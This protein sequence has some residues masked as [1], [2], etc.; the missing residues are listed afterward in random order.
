MLAKRE[1]RLRLS[2]EVRWDTAAP[3]QLL[4]IKDVLLRA[5]LREDTMS[6]GR[7]RIVSLLTVTIATAGVAAVS[8][9]PSAWAAVQPGRNGAPAPRAS[10]VGKGVLSAVSATSASNAWAVG[11]AGSRRWEHTVILRWNGT[12]WS[13]VASPDPGSFGSSLSAVSATSRTSAW[14]VGIYRGSSAFASTALILHWNGTDWSKAG[15][16]VPDVHSELTAVSGVSA[17]SAWAVGWYT[18]IGANRSLILHWNGTRWSKVPSPDPCPYGNYLSAVSATSPTSAWAVGYCYL[19]SGSRTMILHWNGTR[20]SRVPSP[21]P[22]AGSRLTGVAALSGTA[23]WAVGSDDSGSLILRWNGTRWTRVASPDPGPGGNYL[24]AV[25][26][27]SRTSAWAVGRYGATPDTFRTLTLHW[28][29]TRWTKVA[30]P[31]HETNSHDF[32]GLNGVSATAG[33]IAWTVGGHDVTRQPRTLILR[34]NGTRWIR[35]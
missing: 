17:S 6:R 16:P 25:S 23:A 14:A 33:A 20:W 32:F 5:A 3:A 31:G 27:A 1:Q 34:W 22:G 19:H 29:G 26:A 28:D 18:A 21:S 12:R 7:I 10:A 35:A 11:A 8:V 4:M 30:S 13:K 2:H 9:L 15:S 24:S